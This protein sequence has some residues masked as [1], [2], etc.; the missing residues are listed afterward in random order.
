MSAE[1]TDEVLL[2][3]AAVGAA[4]GRPLL[5][6]GAIRFEIGMYRFCVRPIMSCD[7]FRYIYIV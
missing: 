3:Y 6:G 1:L 5:A 4:I 2:N 7:G